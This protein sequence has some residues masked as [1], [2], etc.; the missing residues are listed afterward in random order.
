MKNSIIEA[1]DELNILRSIAGFQSTVQNEL[2]AGDGKDHN[3]LADYI[4][5]DIRELDNIAKRIQEGV[6]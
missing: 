4:V 2:V 3:L 1:T 6:S 5:N